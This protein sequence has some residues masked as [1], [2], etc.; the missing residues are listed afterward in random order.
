MTVSLVLT[1]IGADKPGLVERL[2]ETI[3]AH[4]GNWEASRMAH[5]AGHFA[6]ILL[7]RVPEDQADALAHALQHLSTQGLHIVV[8]HSA[9]TAVQPVFHPYRLEL[10]GHDHPGIVRDISRILANLGV[11]V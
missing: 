7:T 3:A 8:H 1:C 9:S 6:G 10:T 4:G 11:N 5:L 2:A